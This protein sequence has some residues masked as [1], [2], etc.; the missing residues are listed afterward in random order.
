MNY[1][2]QTQTLKVTI[3]HISPV[4]KIHYVYRVVVEKNGE[5]QQAYLYQ[6][7]PSII[8]NKYT[9]NIPAVSGDVLTVSAYCNLFGYLSKSQTIQ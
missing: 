7:Q 2:Q 6:R 1:N 3:I 8:F 5:V 9:Y 4:M